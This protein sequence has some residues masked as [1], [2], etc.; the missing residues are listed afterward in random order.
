MVGMTKTLVIVLSETR[1]FELTFS[2]FKENV[3]DTLNADLCVCI[4]VRPDYDYENPYYKLAK[5]RFLYDEPDDYGDAFDYAYNILTSQNEN[6]EIPIHWREFLKIGDQFLGGVKDP[7]HQHPGSAGILIFFRW[8]LLKNLLEND[9][10]TQY[11][12]FIIT[13]S[14]FIYRLPHPMMDLLD[15]TNIW[16]PDGEHY[17]GYTDRHVV[18]SQKTVVPYLNIFNNF[19]VKSNEYYLKMNT[20]NTWNLEKVLKFNLTENN[21]IHLV[22]EFP[23]I[24]YSVRNVNGSTRWSSGVYNKALGYFVKYQSEFEQ[25]EKYKHEF[26]HSKMSINEFY[27]RKLKIAMPQ[28]SQSQSQSHHTQ[29]HFFRH[30]AFNR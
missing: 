12:R 28:V 20:D 30:P 15:D 26:E 9:I 6:H 4:G 18:L 16:I 5:Y 13:R 10:I 24:M 22:K 23:Y 1:A 2:N 7:H 14:D 17:G 21:V 11:D 3:I 27:K 25:S 8:F 29:T 19:V